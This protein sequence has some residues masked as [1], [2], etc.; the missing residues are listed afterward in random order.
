M[1]HFGCIIRC[2]AKKESISG[3]LKRDYRI[4]SLLGGEPEAI[5]R[6]GGVMEDS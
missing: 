4:L 5:F 3:D 6:G 1:F 2:K